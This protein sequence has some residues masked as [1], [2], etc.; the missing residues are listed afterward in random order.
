MRASEYE[1]CELRWNSEECIPITVF[2][3]LLPSFFYSSEA[4]HSALFL[5]YSWIAHDES[6]PP[7]RFSTSYDLKHDAFDSR[8]IFQ[9]NRV[10]R[11]LKRKEAHVSLQISFPNELPSSSLHEKAVLQGKDIHPDDSFKHSPFRNYTLTTSKQAFCCMHN[12][13][14]S[15]LAGVRVPER[16]RDRARVVFAGGELLAEADRELGF[17]T[18]KNSSFYR[19]LTRYLQV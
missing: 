15:P 14:D 13:P 12:F 8:S 7:R 16:A 2:V 10:L 9:W 3:S 18:A 11:Y 19:N 6:F 1:T 17:G 4:G 5:A